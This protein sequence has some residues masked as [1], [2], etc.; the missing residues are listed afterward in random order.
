MTL[1]P[2]LLAFGSVKMENNVEAMPNAQRNLLLDILTKRLLTKKEIKTIEELFFLPYFGHISLV[3][4][5]NN[6]KATAK[7]YKR[8]PT[9]EKCGKG[10]SEVTHHI[11]QNYNDNRAI[12]L[13][14]LCRACHKQIHKQGTGWVIVYKYQPNAVGVLQFKLAKTRKKGRLA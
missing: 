13:L 8:K 14:F 9:C 1:P 5:Y 6:R 10:N 4:E 3:G 12:N 11:N 2:L 7:Y